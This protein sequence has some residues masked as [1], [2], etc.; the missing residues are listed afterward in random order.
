MKK[1]S[2]IIATIMLVI[3]LGFIVYAINHPELSW[4]WS[5]AVTFTIYGIYLLI[6]II[7]FIAPFK[8]K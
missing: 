3:A 8:N 6:M 5:N 2:R 7:L 1:I 4:P